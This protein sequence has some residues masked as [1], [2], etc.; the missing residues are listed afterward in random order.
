MT[1]VGPV[2][3][4]WA[5]V[6]AGEGGMARRVAAYLS[7]FDASLAITTSVIPVMRPRG[8]VLGSTYSESI[9]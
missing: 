7:D 8:K 9:V 5:R 2:T 1:P 6:D 4:S 3:V